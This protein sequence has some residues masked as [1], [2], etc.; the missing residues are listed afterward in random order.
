MKM[1]KAQISAHYLHTSH[2]RRVTQSCVCVGL[3][4]CLRTEP[5]GAGPREE[6]RQRCRSRV[7]ESALREGRFS[8]PG[9]CGGCL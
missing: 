7:A 2:S 3:N 9:D 8:V 1:M 4:V 6:R 5:C